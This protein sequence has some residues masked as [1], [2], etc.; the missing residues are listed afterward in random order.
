[1]KATKLITD[2]AVVKKIE[3][4]SEQLE[5]SLASMR[6]DNFISLNTIVLCSPW[7]RCL[8]L[9]LFCLLPATAVCINVCAE[10]F[11]DNDLS[12]L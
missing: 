8:M 1:M 9:N 5:C 4:A 7:V 10:N 11:C 2:M 3:A 6:V 12:V